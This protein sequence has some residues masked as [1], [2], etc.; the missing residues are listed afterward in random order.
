MTLVKPRCLFCAPINTAS[1]KL[2]RKNKDA[3]YTV[4]RCRTL[5]V[6]APNTWSVTLAPNAAPSPSCFGR[7][8]R[9]NKVIS[10]HTITNTTNNRLMIIGSH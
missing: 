9:I 4:P 3:K 5:V 8:I 2:T 1:V 10:R 7:C 6:R